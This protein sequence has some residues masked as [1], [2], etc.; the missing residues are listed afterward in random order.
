MQREI[1]FNDDC[2]H[3]FHKQVSESFKIS[4]ILHEYESKMNMY[5]EIN[6]HINLN[7]LKS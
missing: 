6:L 1:N 5:G 4:Q 7:L 3:R 2:R